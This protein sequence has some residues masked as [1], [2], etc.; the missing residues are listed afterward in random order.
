LSRVD[1]GLCANALLI[2]AIGHSVLYAV[3]IARLRL[4]DVRVL[5]LS[6]L[7][8]W[9]LLGAILAL[10]LMVG[11]DPDV[12]TVALVAAVVV[13]VGVLC[14]RRAPPVPA[15][16]F[17][18]ERHPLAHAG[19]LLGAAILATTCLGGLMLSV[20]GAGYAD[21]VD[22]LTFWIPKAASIF[23][24]HGL[25]AEALRSLRHSEYPPLVP[26]MNAA[27]FHFVGGFHP[28][29][30]PFQM[31][32]LGVAFVLASIALVD[33]FAPRW[34][35]LPALALLTTTPWFWWRLQSPLADQPLA[36]TVAAA[37]LS[38]IIWLRERRPA[39]LA[40]AFAFLTA[41]SLTK[42]E[43]SM[44]AVLLILV[45]L[46]AAVLMHGRVGLAAGWLALAPATIIPWHIWLTQHGLRAS[47]ADYD[48]S[49]LLD[50][51]LLA[52]RTDRLTKTLHWMW[53]AP[54]HQLQTAVLVWVVVAGLVAAAIRV[55]ALTA[56]A[57]SWLA[58]SCAGLASVY[59]IGKLEISFYLSSSLSR[60]GTAIIIAA[61]V[62]TPLLLGLALHHDTVS[63]D[64]R[65]EPRSRAAAEAT[66]GL[67]GPF[68]RTLR[69]LGSG[70]LRRG[71]GRRA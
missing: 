4:A 10:G 12:V 65:D 21:Y 9:S 38:C 63:A 57:A 69:S 54:Q 43:G 64:G 31:A 15:T 61:A 16:R 55:P 11:L 47:A 48:A 39:W 32:L 62:L 41:A 46:T 6:Y 49:D 45:V 40:V 44:L 58:L 2:V 26:A 14:G 60:V 23:Y 42:L 37:A 53:G 7:L 35:T 52:E 25:D 20:K 59:W 13:P 68:T 67:P 1:I 33:R 5:G 8:G 28:S 71:R 36:Y 3:G 34:I 66:V 27:T 19:A 17:V 51:G 18:R 56:A 22:N 24:S 70:L 50:P 29:V 30:L